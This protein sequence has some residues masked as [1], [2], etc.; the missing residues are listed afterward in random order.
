MVLMVSLKC[1]VDVLDEDG[2]DSLSS[3]ARNSDN[4]SW[5]GMVQN[6]HDYGR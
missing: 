2:T 3:V 4:S 1:L 5:I 6:R